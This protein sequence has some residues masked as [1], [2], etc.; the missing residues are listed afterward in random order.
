MQIR[1]IRGDK[2]QPPI[3]GN[4]CNFALSKHLLQYEKD[5]TLCRIPNV[6]MRVGAAGRPLRLPDVAAEGDALFWCEE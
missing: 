1:A 5:F 4:I 6:V 3:L 2:E